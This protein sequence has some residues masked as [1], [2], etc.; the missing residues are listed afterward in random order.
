MYKVETV[1]N[2]NDSTTIHHTNINV[3]KIKIVSNL[4]IFP[5]A[6]NHFK[7]KLT[8]QRLIN[9]YVRKRAQV[10][11]FREIRNAPVPT[12][13]LNS[14]RQMLNSLSLS[15]HTFMAFIFFPKLANL[16]CTSFKVNSRKTGGAKKI[17]ERLFHGYFHGKM[18]TNTTL[19]RARSVSR[20]DTK[21]VNVPTQ[22][23]SG[24][25]MQ[26]CLCLLME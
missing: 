11:Y 12:P 25:F 24:L 7:C 8:F 14:F 15:Q 23:G 26:R 19:S 16:A 4:K 22:P 2:S 21:K 17:Y 3:Q 6:R 18:D 13:N 20:T 5:I 10:I 9:T 1:Q